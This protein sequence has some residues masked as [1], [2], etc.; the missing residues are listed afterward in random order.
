MPVPRP[1]HL[2]VVRLPAPP[3]PCDSG[4]VS[5]AV[6]RIEWCGLQF[7]T[8]DFITIVCAVRQLPVDATVEWALGEDLDFEPVGPTDLAVLVAKGSPGSPSGLITA[9]VNGTPLTP[10]EFT[11]TGDCFF[12]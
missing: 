7:P 12:V 9:T 10:V 4:G 1:R 5:D 3:P 8:A 11:G 2:A 6:A